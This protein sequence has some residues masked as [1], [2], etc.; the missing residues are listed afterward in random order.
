MEAARVA[1]QRGHRVVLFEKASGLGGQLVVAAKPPHK[2]EL[3]NLIQYMADQLSRAGVEV[4]L[5]REANPE[6]IAEEKPNAVIIATGGRSIKPDIPG[7]DDSKVVTAEEVLAGKEIGKNVVIIGGGMVGCET[8]HFLAEKG[9]QVTLI[10]MLKRL[11][12][13]VS[14]MVR[15]R[16]LDGLREKQVVMMK[17]AKCEEITPKGVLCSLGT[18]EQQEIP[19]DSIILAVGYQPN[20]R[21]FHDLEDRI[22]D[23]TC[24]GDAADPQRIREAIKAGYQAGLSV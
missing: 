20:D 3:T 16:L 15:R 1:S 9:H 5:N 6:N 13:D 4:R 8:G 22:S 24:V 10:E 18:G 23:I 14:P 7:I 2:E 12:N 21:L 17:E 19:A 11:A